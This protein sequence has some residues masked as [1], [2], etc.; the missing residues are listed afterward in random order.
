MK[1]IKRYRELFRIKE[2]YRHNKMDDLVEEVFFGDYEQ[3]WE[4]LWRTESIDDIK[5][6]FEFI[7]RMWDFPE[8][9]RFKKY[10]K[11]GDYAEALENAFRNDFETLYVEYVSQMSDSD[12]KTAEKF[13]RRMHQ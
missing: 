9:I 3:A 5:E 7:A 6:A 1:K 10:R 4:A 8:K 11:Q 2:S 12:F 13:I